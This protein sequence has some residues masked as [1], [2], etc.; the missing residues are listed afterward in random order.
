MNLLRKMVGLF[1][2]LLLS[3]APVAVLAA[4]TATDFPPPPPFQMALSGICADSTYLYVIAHGKILQYK[5]A[6]MSLLQT[7]DLPELTP[8]SDAPPPPPPPTTESGTMPPPPP[9]HMGLPHGA[10]VGN[11]YLYVLAGHLV[12]Q[13]RTPDLTIKATTE[14]PAPEPPSGS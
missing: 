6:D 11:G 5:L 2:G 10:W 4:D 12:H 7:V 1:V 3:V 14:L 13:Y 9:H 8:P